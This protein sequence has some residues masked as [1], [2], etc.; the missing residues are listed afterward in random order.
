MNE[1]NNVI[2]AVFVWIM[3]AAVLGCGLALLV[4]STIRALRRRARSR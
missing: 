1:A 3:F 4:V 2:A